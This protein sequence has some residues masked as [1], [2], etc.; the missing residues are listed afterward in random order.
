MNLTSIR[1]DKNCE[2]FPPCSR[3]GLR[4][5][6]VYVKVLTVKLILLFEIIYFGY[7]LRDFEVVNKSLAIGINKKIS[8]KFYFISVF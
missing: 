2:V 3:R 6:D 1:T 8:Y 5:Y 7:V 4:S